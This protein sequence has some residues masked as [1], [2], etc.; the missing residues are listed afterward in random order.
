MNEEK[1]GRDDMKSRKSFREKLK[2]ND[3]PK[4]VDIPSK[5]EKKFRKGRMLIPNPLDIEKLI[6]EVKE[7]QLVTITQIREKLERDFSVDVSCPLTTGI[8][9]RLIAEAAEEERKAGKEDITPYW[10]VIRDDGSLN[11]KFP[12]GAE[13]QK[14]YLEKEGH[15]IVKKGKKLKVLDFEKFLVRF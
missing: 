13:R 5:I 2:K 15:T 11:E 7:G 1:E 14:V 4:I 10:R 8:F 6:R 12:G 9:I 3:L